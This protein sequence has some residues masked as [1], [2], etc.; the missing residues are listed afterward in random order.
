MSSVRLAR[1]YLL[2]LLIGIGAMVPGAV[3]AQ[4]AQE[5]VFFETLFAACNANG[6]GRNPDL[7]FLLN[8]CDKV[9]PGGVLA[10]GVYAPGVGTVNVGSAGSYGNAGQ[11][12]LQRQ[13]EIDDEEAKKRKKKGGGASADFTAG[14]FG[15]FVTAQT[16]RTKRALTDLEN[17]YK[18]DLNGLLIGLDRRF[19]NSLVVGA[20]LGRTNTD[21]TYLG[22]AGTMSAR[23]TTLMLYATYLPVPGAYLGGYVGGGRGSQD[24]TRRIS[25]G[26]IS[27]TAASSTDSRQTMGGLSGGYDLY[28]GALTVGVNAAMDTVRNR[29]DETTESGTTGLEFIY[30]EQTTSSRTGTLGTRASYRWPFTWGAIVP[31]V[32]AAYVHEYR[33]NARTVSPRLVTGP[34]VVIPF[35]TDSPDRDYYVSGAGATLEAGRG[36][37]FFVDYEKR[38]GHAFIDTWS[39]SIGLIAEF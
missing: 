28:F 17:G 29:T 31:S 20:S 34:S 16:S 6:T 1:Q 10:G 32:R 11:S 38:G 4:V 39:A 13:R 23:N 21:S 30:P 14:A 15:G 36:L 3:Q 25:A 18:A 9:F 2:H 7:A 24:A 8:V 12:G 33:D 5:K 22:D 26:S 35:R 19:G 37:Q 27:G